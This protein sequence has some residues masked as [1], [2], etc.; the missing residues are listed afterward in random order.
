MFAECRQVTIIGDSIAN[1]QSGLDGVTLQIFRGLTIS[2][3]GC[4]IDNA[5]LEPYD[6]VIILTGTNDIGY[7]HSF[8]DIISDYG[9][10]V[11]I[12]C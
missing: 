6:Y 12:C 11:G 7:R 1:H 5:D 2:Q 8:R 3:I 9:N 10:L 4:K